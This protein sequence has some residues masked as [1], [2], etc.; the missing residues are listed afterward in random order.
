[1]GTGSGDLNVAT[2][3]EHGQWM[4]KLASHLVHDTATAEDLVQ[5]TWVAALRSPP[6]PARPPRPWLAQ[7][8]RNLVRSGVRHD[9][10][11]RDREAAVQLG[12]QAP[13]AQD[14]LE[15]TQLH[16]DIAALMAALDEPYRTTLLMRFHEGRSSEAIGELNGV[17]AGTV[18][19][20][21]NEGIRRLREGLDARYGHRRTWVVVL[22]P[23]AGP[24]PGSTGPTSSLSLGKLAVVG[25]L[26]GAA[27]L[28][29][30]LWQWSTPPS[31]DPLAQPS[32]ASRPQPK[33]NTMNTTTAAK[34][35]TPFVAALPI[36]V[37]SAQAQADMAALIEEGVDLCVEVREKVFECKN[38]FAEAFVNQRNPPPEQR[39]A[40]VKK[41]L[42]E[43]VAD[44]SG[45]VEPRRDK[46]RAMAKRTQG[47][48]DEAQLRGKLDGMKKVLAFCAGKETC[49]DRVECMKD[50]FKGGGGK[51]PAKK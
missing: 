40:L 26:A 9:S 44:G 17:P 7:V 47:S 46:C 34:R 32:L 22:L 37:A 18:R 41:A 5:D 3:L 29:I 13:S 11:R 45:P 36:L 33:E 4:R 8:L 27:A 19:W 24:P 15:R 12:E 43:I 10:R 39:K 31:P 23:T 1:M 14:V 51:A 38:E 42:E 48:Q 49:S 21:I 16:R 28:T 20:R 6:D 50:F 2:L 30:G 35:L 25:G